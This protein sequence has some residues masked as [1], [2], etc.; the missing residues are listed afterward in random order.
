M[1]LEYP[2]GLQSVRVPADQVHAIFIIKINR[3]VI[4][5]KKI[6]PLFYILHCESLRSSEFTVEDV[7]FEPVAVALANLLIL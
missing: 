6:L 3:F 5:K 4:V 2:T 7:R 1:T